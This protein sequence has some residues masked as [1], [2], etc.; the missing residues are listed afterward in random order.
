MLTWHSF[1]AVSS[2]F[3]I[4]DFFTV[5]FDY[6]SSSNYLGS[7]ST[8]SLSFKDNRTTYEYVPLMLLPYV[9]YSYHI[10]ATYA[11]ESTLHLLR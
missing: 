9:D 8:R 6:L 5:L 3:S 1:L 7:N 2:F 11:R 4:L 10:Q